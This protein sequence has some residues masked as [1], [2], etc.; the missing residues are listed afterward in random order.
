MKARQ[1]GPTAHRHSLSNDCAARRTGKI[2]AGSIRRS[3]RR[4]GRRWSMTRSFTAARRRIG[5]CVVCVYS[6]RAQIFG[7]ELTRFPQFNSGFFYRQ[8]VLEKYDFYW[9]VEPG[10]SMSAAAPSEP[11]L[12]ALAPLD[13]YRAQ[14]RRGYGSLPIHGRQQ[15]SLWIHHCDV[16]VRED[17]SDAVCT[18]ITPSETSPLTVDL[19]A[20]GKA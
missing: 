15:Q 19:D 18:R 1:D 9:R 4:K 11:T 6:C 12:M 3:R 14:V 8:K 7:L 10:G 20:G 16:R 17:H 13:R 5:R 2:L